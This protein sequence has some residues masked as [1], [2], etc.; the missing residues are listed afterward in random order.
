M[1]PPD[2][3]DRAWYARL[4]WDLMIL[5]RRKAVKDVCCQ[6]YLDKG[7]ACKGCALLYGPDAE[8]PARRFIGS[9]AKKKS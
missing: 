3:K 7:R 6:S 9:I 2:F 5:L 8:N 1:L 4:W